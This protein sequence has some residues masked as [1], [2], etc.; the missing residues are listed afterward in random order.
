MEL[1]DASVAKMVELDIDNNFVVEELLVAVAVV[2]IVL[3]TYI[4]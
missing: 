2:V 1:E 3:D 4:K